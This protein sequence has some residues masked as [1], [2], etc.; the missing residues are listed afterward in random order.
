MK[1]TLS[2]LLV[3][4]M[5]LAQFVIPVSAFSDE[6]EWVDPYEG[7]EITSLSAVANRSLIMNCDG[8]WSECFC[9]GDDGEYYF[10]YSVFA[11]GTAS[12]SGE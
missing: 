7:L 2:L 6:E 9:N 11:F 12:G 3:L 1:K 4:V 10:Y 8:F 5:L